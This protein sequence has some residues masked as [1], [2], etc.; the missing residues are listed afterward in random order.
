MIEA[1]KI[2]AGFGFPDAVHRIERYVHNN[3][4]HLLSHLMELRRVSCSSEQYHA[5]GDISSL[6]N[7]A[8]D[9]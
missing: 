9:P 4:S 2:F 5:A 8:M 3:V 1:A 7:A 6:E